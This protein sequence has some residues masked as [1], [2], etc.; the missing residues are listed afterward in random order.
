MISDRSDE[1]DSL[2][3]A[4]LRAIDPLVMQLLVDD[5]LQCIGITGS[6]AGAGASTISWNFA[7][8]AT[9]RAA[10]RVLLIDCDPSERSLSSKRALRGPGLVDVLGKQAELSD[11]IRN[12]AEVSFLPYGTARKRI[13]TK[14]F[15]QLMDAARI[16]FDTIVLDLPESAVHLAACA[17]AVLLV[18]EA[19]VTTRSI[20]RG[21]R[22]RLVAAGANVIG[23]VFNKHR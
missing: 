8:A 13:P 4:R 19:N 6:G 11:A 21:T 17:D 9:L 2:D 18:V 3:S 14:A 16:Q 20:A 22:K 15:R 7:L 12:F 5:E 23:A 10:S 1:F